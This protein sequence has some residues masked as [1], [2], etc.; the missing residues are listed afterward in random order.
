MEFDHA[1]LR[2]LQL[3]LSGDN[4]HII[5]RSGAPTG[6]AT[7][8]YSFGI[9]EEYFLADAASLEAR[10]TTPDDFFEAVN[11]STG[12][13]AMREMLQAQVEV[14]T[15]VHVDVRDACQELKFL[16]QEASK[17]AGQFGLAIMASGTHPTAFWRDSRLSPKARYEA[18]IE[19][20]RAV[21]R[22]NLLCGMHV[23][24]QLPD[25]AKRFAVMCAMVPYLPLFIA[26]ASSSPF[27]NGRATGLKGYRLAAYDEL[28][29]TGLPELFRTQDEFQSYVKALTH[30]GAMPDESYIWW[31]MRPS[32]RH[33]TLELRAPD[34]CTKLE[35]AIGI[36]SLYRALARH[37]F[38]RLADAEDVTILDRAIAVENKWRAQ[39]YGVE[40][41]F[42]TKSGPLALP[43][44]LSELIDRIADDA[45]YL[46]CRGEVEHCKTIARQGSSADHQLRAAEQSEPLEAAKRFIANATI[47]H[48]GADR[49]KVETNSTAPG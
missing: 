40:C 11:W 48:T 3:S 10:H 41:S 9:E 49:S 24:V 13:Q 30:S 28:P 4:R 18:M 17:V 7:A 1:I 46:R 27:W 32:M 42:V 12:G 22:R 8:E 37:L 36:A 43:D 44:F 31:A 33:P 16:R 5:I 14:A 26:L 20:L 45:E 38:D 25:P 47:G 34:C 15:N 39:R 29:R 35:D 19:D 23:H 6:V 21:G 2:G